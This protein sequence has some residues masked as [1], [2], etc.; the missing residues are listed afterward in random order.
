M[1]SATEKRHSVVATAID[2]ALEATVLGSFSRVGIIVRRATQHW[3]DEASP[4]LQGKTALVTGATSGIGL[5]AAIQMA[6]RGAAVRIVGRNEAKAAA[7]QSTIRR[8]S[9]E[10]SDVDFDVVDVSDFDAVRAFAKRF[11]AANASLDVLVH[12]AG[13]LT[14]DY[15]QAP[16]GCEATLAAHVLGP[17]LLTSLLLPTLRAASNHATVITVSSGGMYT[18]RLDLATLEMTANDYKGATAY[19]RAKRAQVV[20]NHEWSKRIP[21]D[22]IAFHAMHPGWVDTPGVESGLPTFYRV[23]K[24]LLRT[25]DDGAD[26]IV[27]LAGNP[28]VDSGHFWLDRRRRSEHHVPWTRGGDANALWDYCVERTGA[29]PVA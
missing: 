5:A 4:S 21:A 7:A 16:S 27:W 9:G 28:S 18:E 6:K 17:F 8:A 14:A 3:S 1:T 12:N 20:L 24:P 26:T 10:A 19:A 11:T 29:P 25:P 15:R 22:Q 13:A 23:M 2:A